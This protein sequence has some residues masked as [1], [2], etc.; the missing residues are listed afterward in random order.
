LGCP[1]DALRDFKRRIGATERLHDASPHV[2]DVVSV[3]HACMQV[4]SDREVLATF[5]LRFLS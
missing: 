5:W 1:C 2:V 4:W 3:V